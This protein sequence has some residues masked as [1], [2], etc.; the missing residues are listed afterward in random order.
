MIIPHQ[1]E[2]ILDD[3][4]SPLQEEFPSI[5]LVGGAVRDQLLMQ[6]SKDIDLVCRNAAQ[7][8]G[9]LAARRDATVVVFNKKMD[10]PCYRVVDKKNPCIFVDVALLRGDHIIDDLKGRDFTI[11]AMAIPIE[12][13]K[14]GDHI[15][16]PLNGE[17]DL[18]Q[19]LVKMAAPGAITEDPLRVLRAVRFAAELNFKIDPPT[20][21]A[22]KDRAPLLDRVPAERIWP[23]L[24]AILNTKKSSFFIRLMDHLT[25]LEALFPEING[26]KGC[27]QNDFHH[28]T[29]WE[30]SLAVMS[31]CEQILEHLEDHFDRHVGN[32][33]KN[34]AGHNRQ[35]LLKLSALFHDVGKPPSR[36]QDDHTGKTTF[37]N[38]D[39][40]GR[41]MVPALARRLKMSNREQAFIEILI[42]E[43]LHVSNLLPP[44][45]KASTRMQWFRRHEDDAIPIIILAMADIRGKLGPLSDK[46]VRNQNLQRAGE[47]IHS[48]YGQIRQHIKQADLIKGKDLMALGMAPGAAMGYVLGQVRQARD[49]GLVSSREDALDLIKKL[50]PPSD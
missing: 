17:N 21:G 5:Y 1:I 37:Y 16:D 31:H 34:L 18:K 38:H 32:I 48:Y 28:L 30:H 15:I 42:A 13:G 20:L 45:V 39:Q 14:I 49:D 29:V 6:P 23:E 7:L 43:H 12:S 33:E 46:N 19:G 3:W 40:A 36:Q 10:S 4:L 8:A 22:M 24:L 25:I 50:A 41:R 47:L 44:E 2:K 35:A 26:M 27:V 11:N 9:R